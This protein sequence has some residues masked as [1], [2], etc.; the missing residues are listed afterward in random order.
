MHEEQFPPMPEAV[1]VHGGGVNLSHRYTADQMR[2]YGRQCAS[3]AKPQPTE[4]KAAF[5][6]KYQRDSEDPTCAEELRLFGDGW[7]AKPQP[8]GGLPPLS[9]A[10]RAV[11]RNENDVYGDEDALYAALFAATLSAPAAQPGE[12]EPVLLADGMTFHQVIGNELFEFQQ[13]TGCDTA[14]QYR[15]SQEAAVPEAVAL[16]RMFQT[17]LGSSRASCS[18]YDKSKWDRIEAVCNGLAVPE[19]PTAQAAAVPEAVERER[20]AC[21]KVVEDFGRWLGTA[22]EEIAAAIRARKAG[23]SDKGESNAANS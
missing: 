16:L 20:E 9:D 8:V 2:E 21:A 14:E 4:M 6:E 18:S 12:A 1:C 15:A 23:A 7:N 17:G 3:L 5:E 13:A 10:M 19:T 11:L 22:R